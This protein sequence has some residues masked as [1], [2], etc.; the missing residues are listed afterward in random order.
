MPS[1]RY[2]GRHRA[3]RPARAAWLTPMAWSAIGLAAS[4]GLVQSTL[5]APTS[6]AAV[7]PAAAD[8]AQSV[9]PTLPN[10]LTSAAAVIVDTSVVAAH[11]D[12]PAGAVHDA[13]LA[14]GV[15][16]ILGTHSATT[17]RSAATLRTLAATTPLNSSVSAGTAGAAAGQASAMVSNVTLTS[18]FGP[19][20]GRLH[21]GVDFAG[22]VGT[23]IRA[24]KAGTVT[25]VGQQQGYGNKVELTL[26]DGTV[27]YFAHL[28]SMSVH[29]GQSV[30]AG[31]TI[32]TL[33]NTGRSTGPHLH[34]EVHPGGGGPVDPEPWLRANGVHPLGSPARARVG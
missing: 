5:V 4:A 33:G 2:T 22:P 6:Q 31:Q 21:A 32:A 7:A 1:E 29:K 14:S 3:T 8:V 15:A 25:F 10:S 26:A 27:L 12:I 28:H 16:S 9:G 18:R 24:P 19:R 20:W 17:A 30:A 34:F 11:S 23:P 13:H